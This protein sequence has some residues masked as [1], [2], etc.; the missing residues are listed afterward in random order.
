[1]KQDLTKCAET[2]KWFLVNKP[3]TRDNDMLLAQ[4]IWKAQL[5]QTY[6]INVMTVS[7]FFKM[8]EKYYKESLW[9]YE[10]I[11]RARRRLQQKHADLRGEMYNTRMDRQRQKIKEINNID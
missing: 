1:M 2:V 10:S 5:K 9:Q 11:V 6:Y 3:A 8:M 4:E 7:Q